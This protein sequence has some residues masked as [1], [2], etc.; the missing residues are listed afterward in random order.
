MELATNGNAVSARGAESVARSFAALRLPIQSHVSVWFLVEFI[1][2]Q[3]W[4][5]C[6]L[7]TMHIEMYAYKALSLLNVIQLQYNVK[8]GNTQYKSTVTDRQLSTESMWRNHRAIYVLEL[9][10]SELTRTLTPA[11]K[12]IAMEFIRITYY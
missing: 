8:Y 10:P 4:K 2:I 12:P 7:K 6:I 5:L 3:Y 1:F 11:F 9:R